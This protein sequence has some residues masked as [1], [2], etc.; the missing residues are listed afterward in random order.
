[1]KT[2]IDCPATATTVIGGKKMICAALLA[3]VWIA[4]LNRSVH[5][6]E[7]PAR[8]FAPYMYIGAGD[9]FFTVRAIKRAIRRGTSLNT[10]ERDVAC[11]RVSCSGRSRKR[12]S[13]HARPDRAS[14]PL[15]K[16]VS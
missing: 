13:R 1:M 15:R 2:M 3:S 11:A 4:G 6:G 16:A 5:A 9:N 8:V 10:N 14:L 12:A 7:W